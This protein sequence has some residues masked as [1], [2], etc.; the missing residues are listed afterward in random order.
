M[1]RRGVEPELGYE[2]AMPRRGSGY[3]AEA[4][5]LVTRACHSAGHAHIWATIRPTNVTS[6]RTVLAAGYVFVRSESDGNRALDYYLH[7]S[8]EAN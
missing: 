4:A 2:I 8:G 7:A 3:A 5:G 6:I 1:E